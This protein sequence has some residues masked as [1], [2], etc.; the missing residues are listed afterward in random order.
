MAARNYFG[1]LEPAFV[2]CVLLLPT[3]ALAVSDADRIA[4]YKEFRAQ[5]D[6]KKYAEAQ[7]LA[8]R[9]VALTEEQY[10]A[11]ELP[12]TNPLTNL[13]TVHY[14]Q[15]HYA[16][17]IENYQRSLRILQAKSTLADK[18][19]IRPLHGL[20][21]SFMGANDP[22]SAVVALK[23]AADLSRNTD[24]LFNINQVEFIDALIDAYEA[25]GRYVEAEKES[26]YAMRVEEAAYGRT[27]IKLLDRLDKL[28]HWY[29]GGRRY[30]SERNTYEKAL[31]ILSRSATENDL[32]RVGPLRG[33]A[34]SF[35]LETF[36]GVEGADNGSTFNSGGNGAP[37]F[38]DGTQQRR[39]ES[40]LTSALAIIDA[41]SPAN[42]QMRGEVLTDLGDWYLV[43]N[44][45][46]RAYDTYADAWKALASAANTKL[47][48]QPRVL[49]YRPSISSVDRSQLD[50]AES[51][52]RTVELH[53]KVD[54][55]GRIDDVTSPTTDV[56]EAI[57]KNSMVS[58]KRSRFAPRIENGAAVPTENVVFLE[59]VMIKVIPPDSGTSSAKGEEKKPEEK[60]EEKKSEEK[61]EE[62]PKEPPPAQ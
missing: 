40:S 23:R 9:L 46:R 31:A 25:S 60:P 59:R 45:L 20:G 6:A 13:A 47:L 7:P 30:T 26:L 1:W 58:M 35:R 12:L 21:V 38:A 5:Y 44:S 55:D 18:Q 39:G 52:V 4:V 61:K 50:P 48:E 19:Q 29:E 8:E 53:F 49:A 36:Y 56:P 43:S 37:V 17:A 11:E 10:G 15:G 34:R 62:S 54:R 16:A 24:G 51:V 32:R 57:V 28:A 41:N 22:D 14:K 2:T 3:A 27:S 33:I 42:E